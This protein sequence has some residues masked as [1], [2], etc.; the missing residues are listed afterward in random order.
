MKHSIDEYFEVE[1]QIVD[2]CNLN[3]DNCNHFSNIAEP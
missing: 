3:C 1:I 2:H